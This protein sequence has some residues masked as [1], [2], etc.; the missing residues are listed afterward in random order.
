MFN[1]PYTDDDLRAEAARQYAEVL[2][3]P[4]R[5]EVQ[6]EMQGTAI[7]SRSDADQ[8]VRWGQLSGDEFHD[9]ANEVHELLDD[10]PNLSRWAIDLSA[11]VLTRTTE[12]A[13]GHGDNWHLAVQLAHRRGIHNDL[14]GAFANAIRNAV[15]QV[16]ADRGID[17]PEIKQNDFEQATR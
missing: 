15:N 16:L 5:I 11:C 4:D 10:A 14:S 9:A 17:A 2:R 1:R 3:S 13:W 12:L 8:T 6:D 7:P